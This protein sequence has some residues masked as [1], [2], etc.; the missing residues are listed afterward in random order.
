MHVS[1]AKRRGLDWV[2]LERSLI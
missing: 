2:A 1:S